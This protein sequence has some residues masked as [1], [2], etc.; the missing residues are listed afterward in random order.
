MPT[1]KDTVSRFELDGEVLE[2]DVADLT[3]GEI[4]FAETYFDQAFDYIEW[5]SGR[6][7][8]VIAYLAKKR[9]KPETTLDDFRD[10]KLS[11]IKK[12][13]KTRP[14]KAAAKSSGAQR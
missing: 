4:E 10:L 6:G 9:I 8:L 7:L 11:E 5:Q 14:K 2:I 3:F 12:V 13:K 1:K